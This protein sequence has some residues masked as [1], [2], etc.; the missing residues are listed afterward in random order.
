MQ[1]SKVACSVLLTNV[2]LVLLLLLHPG[3][4]SGQSYL[5]RVLEEGTRAPLVGVFVVLR[6]VD[7]ARIVAALTDPTG[8]YV[9]DASDDAAHHITAER[10]GLTSATADLP[11]ASGEK[12]IRVED[13]LLRDRAIE[14][15]G[16]I[17]DGRVRECALEGGD[18][19][20]IQRWWDEARKAL[21]VTGAGIIER[22]RIHRFER[23]WDRRLSALLREASER[24]V[25]YSDQPFQSLE[26]SSLADDGFVQGPPGD[27]RF[28]APDA[29]VLL[30]DVFLEQHCFSIVQDQARPGRVGLRFEPNR[31]RRK[32]DILGVFWV[33]TLTARL[34][35]LEFSYANLPEEL[36]GSDAGGQVGFSQLSSGAWVVS[37]WWIRMPRVG[38]RSQRLLSGRRDHYEVVGYVDVG[39]TV[40]PL[41]GSAGWADPVPGVGTIRGQVIAGLTGDPLPGAR[42]VVTGTALSTLTEGDG[43]F[44]IPDVP[45]GEWSVTFFHED[46]S[47]I[48]L[49]SPVTPVRV[50]E[51]GESVVSLRGA[52]F[53]AVR[54]A[55]CPSRVGDSETFLY[56]EVSQ[57]GAPFPE[58]LVRATWLERGVGGRQERW[59]E[60]YTGSSGSYV[61]CGL[62]AETTIEVRIRRGDFWRLVAETALTPRRIHLIESRL[63]G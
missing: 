26:A 23:E 14:L 2:A 57:A 8:R 61:F 21:E 39:G 50:E 27:R 43:S 38:R 52:D 41:D 62:P 4:L 29:E 45:A 63:D 18:G 20:L 5:G 11:E 35:E 17:V 60:A 28:Y 48:Q 58:V 9:L 42:V 6:S 37:D 25:T 24:T 44:T 54:D 31:R 47:R 30:S 13:I 36:P 3:A 10:I 22:F 59:V 12:L 33:D 49:P 7:G 40:E 1:I 51:G 16:L 34:E 15:E 46:L 55:L 56:G 53:D 19:V 32:P